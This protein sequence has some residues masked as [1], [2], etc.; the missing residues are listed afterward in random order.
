MDNKNSTYV[1]SSVGVPA[2]VVGVLI[3]LKK[4]GMTAMS[5]S[6]IIWF[7]V[8]VWFVCALIVL[9]IWL[10]VFFFLILFKA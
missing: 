9:A 7:G 3:A 10:I 8:E 1:S 6:D 4:V 5:Y 2:V